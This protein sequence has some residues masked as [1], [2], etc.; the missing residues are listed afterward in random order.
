MVVS[1]LGVWSQ[2]SGLQT[3]G[4]GFVAGNGGLVTLSLLGAGVQ[5]TWDGRNSSGQLVDAGIY[6]AAASFTDSFGSVTLMSSPVSLLRTADNLALTVFNAG[7]EIVRHLWQQTDAGQ[8]SFDLAPAL[9]LLGASVS[10]TV[11]VKVQNGPTL[12]W[13]GRNDQGRLVADGQYLLQLAHGQPA[14]PTVVCVRAVQVL[15]VKGGDWLE[16]VQAAPNPL[17]VGETLRLQW[18]FL[19]AGSLVAQVY[20][21]EGGLVFTA[22][23]ELAAG[24][25]DWRMNLPR[26]SPGLYGLVLHLQFSGQGPQQ[27]LVKLAVRP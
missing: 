17:A 5:L 9:L 18:T 14:A 20:S 3:V 7:G 11:Q 13:D 1:Q 25:G 24:S 19:P 12:A 8:V 23:R 15:S 4:T 6:T 16:A 26:L 2:M 10:P 27:R 21:I 22:E